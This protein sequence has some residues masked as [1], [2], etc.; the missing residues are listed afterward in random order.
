[1]LIRGAETHLS[2]ITST[3]TESHIAMPRWFKLPPSYANSVR[4][5]G[6][7]IVLTIKAVGFGAETSTALGAF[8]MQKVADVVQAGRD[9]LLRLIGDGL[10][11][12]PNGFLLGQ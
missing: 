4:Y 6:Q 9:R 8:I 7:M 11:G 1:M 12:A 10:N 5:V 3:L 2:N